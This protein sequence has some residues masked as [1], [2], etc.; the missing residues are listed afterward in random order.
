MNENNDEHLQCSRRRPLVVEW[1]SLSQVLCCVSVDSY[2]TVLLAVRLLVRANEST[3][4][5]SR[6]TPGLELYRVAM[7]SSLQHFLLLF[8][9]F[10]TS[11]CVHHTQHSNCL[12]PTSPPITHLC[13]RNSYQSVVLALLPHCCL[14]AYKP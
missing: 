12:Q 9:H 10:Y 4:H 2:S 6:T 3:Q 13:S 1:H 8:I 14:S 11:L 5:R 7:L